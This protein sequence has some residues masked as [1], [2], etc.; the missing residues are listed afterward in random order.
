MSKKNP[1]PKEIIIT[2][3]MAAKFLENNVKNRTQRKRVIDSYASDMLAGKWGMSNDAICFDKEERLLNGQH[4]MAAVIKSG[5]SVP[6]YVIHGLPTESYHIMDM[7][8]KRTAADLLS[9]E[10]YPNTTALAGA[11]RVVN[12][13]ESIPKEGFSPSE[14]TNAPTQR[15][16][17]LNILEIVQ[18]HPLLSQHVSYAIH[19]YRFVMKMIGPSQTGGMYHIFST[20]N[21]VL[22]DHFFRKLHKGEN[23]PGESCLHTLRE[24]LLLNMGSTH[25]MS[26]GYR[27]ALIIKVWNYLRNDNETTRLILNS[28]LK[29]M[30]IE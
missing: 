20:K 25:R 11:A 1:V 21:K 19:N 9:I 7:G 2:P 6:M 15:T 29:L 28:D 23:L 17:N 26:I 22:A 12:L 16:N 30:P 5:C 14:I 4:R 24:R 18:T 10:G 13:L 3:E 8:S 27:A